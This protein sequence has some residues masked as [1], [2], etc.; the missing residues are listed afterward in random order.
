MKAAQHTDPNIAALRR[1]VT[2]YMSMAG[3]ARRAAARSAPVRFL[4]F[5]VLSRAETVLLSFLGVP[6]D[7]DAPARPLLPA[8]SDLLL[9]SA[10][11]RGLALLL[12]QSCGMGLWTDEERPA[13]GFAPAHL[14][15]V[16]CPS[17][18]VSFH[19]TS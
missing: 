3:F 13:P 14:T 6:A 2:L 10:R 12:A 4:V 1:V 18:R 11:L 5:L 16:S 7:D 15:E 8:P 17:S 9:L 19:D